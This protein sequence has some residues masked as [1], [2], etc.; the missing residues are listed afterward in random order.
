MMTWMRYNL[1]HCKQLVIIWYWQVFHSL[2]IF[3]TYICPIYVP[4]FPCQG[5]EGSWSYSGNSSHYAWEITLVV[6][7]HHHRS[8]HIGSDHIT[9]NCSSGINCEMHSSISVYHSSPTTW[10]NAE[11][12]QWPKTKQQSNYSL[13]GKKALDW[14][15]HSPNL[16]PIEQIT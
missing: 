1:M 5:C 13:Q 12:G 3:I 10:I 9:A 15:S 4:L 2:C 8:S 16:N 6:M 11:A 14:R 7:P